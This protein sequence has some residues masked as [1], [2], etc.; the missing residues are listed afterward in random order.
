MENKRFCD[1][2]VGDKI[3]EYFEGTTFEHTITKVEN[4]TGNIY[5]DFDKDDKEIIYK[6]Y[7]ELDFMIYS[8]DVYCDGISWAIAT[9]MDKLLLEVSE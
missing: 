9:S 3:Y 4:Q 8:Q 6:K 7:A 1:L 2:I 5:L